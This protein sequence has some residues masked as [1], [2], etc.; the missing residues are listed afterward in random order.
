MPQLIDGDTLHGTITVTKQNGSKI[1]LQ[2][3]E[4]YVEKKIE[5]TIDVQGGTASVPSTSITANPTITVSDTGLVTATCSAS[6]SV[7]PSV[8]AGYVTSG[9]SGTVTVSGS[10]TY[11][12]D[13]ATV[14]ETLAYLG[15]S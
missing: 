10:N 13:V 8:S 11:Q 7:M 6:E 14:A 1:Y 5:L 12:L 3:K 4:T 15:I 2:T 9:T